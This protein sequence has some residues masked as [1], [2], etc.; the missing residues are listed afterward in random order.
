[1]S[2]RLA[3][4]ILALGVLATLPASAADDSKVKA[5]TKQVGARRTAPPPS[6]RA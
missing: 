6:G 5:A 2:V 3:I 1:M 4:L